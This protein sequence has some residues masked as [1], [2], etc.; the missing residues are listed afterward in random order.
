MSN[1]MYD[2]LKTTALIFPF[3]ITFISAIM[4]IWNIPYALEVG[5]TLS[6]LNALIAGIVKVTNDLY[7][8]SLKEDKKK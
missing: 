2:A 5:L 8:K 4:K 1:K 3:V 6:A 7:K